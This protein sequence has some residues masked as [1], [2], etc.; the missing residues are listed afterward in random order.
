MDGVRGDILVIR[1]IPIVWRANRCVWTITVLQT[2]LCALIPL[3]VSPPLC[4]VEIESIAV[5]LLM[6][7]VSFQLDPSLLLL[8]CF[9]LLCF[10]LL[11]WNDLCV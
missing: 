5:F 11:G 1:L 7:T 2:V 9:A 8:L 4:Y 10:V 6:N 3:L